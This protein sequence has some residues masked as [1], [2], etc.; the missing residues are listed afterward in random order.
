MVI[1]KSLRL[2]CLMAAVLLIALP[3]P[4]LL[5]EAADNCSSDDGTCSCDENHAP[6]L[7]HARANTKVLAGFPSAETSASATCP[8]RIGDRA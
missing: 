2:F 3:L 6:I 7:G 4:L 5:S 1:H 8:H